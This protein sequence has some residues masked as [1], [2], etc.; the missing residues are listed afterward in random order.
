MR[1]LVIANP[2]CPEKVMSWICSDTL[3][4]KVEFILLTPYSL[5]IKTEIIVP[6]INYGDGK[7][8]Y[9]PEYLRKHLSQHKV[10]LPYD[11]VLNFVPRFML[12]FH[13]ITCNNYRAMSF[14]VETFNVDI[15]DSGL[16]TNMLDVVSSLFNFLVFESGRD[17]YLT[18]VRKNFKATV[19]QTVMNN[20]TQLSDGVDIWNDVLLP[21]YREYVQAEHLDNPGLAGEVELAA[22]ALSKFTEEELYKKLTE[23]SQSGRQWGRKGDPISRMWI[24]R[25]LQRLGMFPKGVVFDASPLY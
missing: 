7:L 6:T 1:V 22:K 3:G 9:S 12:N 8:I 18:F 4:S 21:R 15:I 17:S 23:L 24:R 5:G 14:Q 2:N 11:M 13:T 20:S 10:E 16:E 19:I 25:T